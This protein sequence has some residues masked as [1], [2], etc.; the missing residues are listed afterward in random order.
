MKPEGR[1]RANCCRLAVA[2]DCTVVEAT[3][4]STG[5]DI[6]WLTDSVLAAELGKL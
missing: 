6:E 3:T 1:N 5:L 2:L 4:L